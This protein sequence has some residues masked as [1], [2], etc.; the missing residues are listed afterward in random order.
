MILSVCVKLKDIYEQGCHFKW[1]RPHACPRCNSVRVWGHG[2]VLAC[3]D[4]F[5]TGLWLRRFRCPDCSC[6]IRM[7]PKGYFP[8]FQTPIHTIL[9]CLTQRLSGDTWNAGLSTSRQRHWL[10]ALKRKTMACFGMGTDWIAAFYRLR[11]RG[12]IPVSRAI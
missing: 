7:K 10:A 1:I 3:F 12:L 2:Y 5:A 11:K 8:R 9:V 4:G 6:I